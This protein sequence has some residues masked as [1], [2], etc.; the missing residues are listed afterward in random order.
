MITTVEYY[1]RLTSTSN[2][3]AFT[4][5]LSKIIPLY[6]FLTEDKTE[7]TYYFLTEDQ[8]FFGIIL[9][10]SDIENKY[11]IQIY[12]PL[13]CSSASS[14]INKIPNCGNNKKIE[15]NIKE[16]LKLQK[17]DTYIQWHDEPKYINKS[18]IYKNIEEYKELL[19]KL[20]LPIF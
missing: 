17:T 9:L 6:Y 19:Q 11:Q 5:D 7:E 3:P 1:Q 16:R 10:T 4:F 20:F 13:T 2:V 18:K 14:V 15:E 12:T 8:L